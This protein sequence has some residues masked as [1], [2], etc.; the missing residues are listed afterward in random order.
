MNDELF[1]LEQ[2]LKR[3]RPRACPEGLLDGIFDEAPPATRIFAVPSAV[4]WAAAAMFVGLIAYI[5][6]TVGQRGVPAVSYDGFS[7]VASSNVLRETRDE[8]YVLLGDG[9]TARRVRNR[10]VDTVT[11]RDAQTNAYLRWSSPREEIRLIPV[12]VY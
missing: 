6:A 11:W 7:P 4:R 8:G 10:Y 3:L 1:E 12:S 5:S 2:E 9:T